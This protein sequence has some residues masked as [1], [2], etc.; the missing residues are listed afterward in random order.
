M[1]AIEEEDLEYP[2]NVTLSNLLY[3][4]CA[5]TLTYQLAFPKYPVRRWWQIASL[6]SRILLVGTLI[7]FL[8]AQIV[9]PLLEALIGELE[10]TGGTYTMPIIAKYWLKLSIANHSTGDTAGKKKTE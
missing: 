8:A 3:F 1:R 7:T 6:V 2:E 10:A 4:W 9:M 5:P